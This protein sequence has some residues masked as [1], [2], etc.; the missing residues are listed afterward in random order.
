M[1]D[2]VQE[3]KKV[4]LRY[5]T[6]EDRDEFQELRIRSRR[7]HKKWEPS[8]PKG[9]DQYGS[10]AFT[11]YCMSAR[12]ERVHRLLVCRHEEGAIVG[13]VVLSEIVRGCFQSAYMGYWVGAP[14]VRRGYLSEGVSLALRHAFVALRLHRVE[15]NIQPDNKASIALAKR[16]GFRLEGFSERYLKIA[17]RW[18]DHERWAVLREEWKKGRR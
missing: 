3:G 11:R 15:A 18:R 8:P 17:G 5:P 12:S 4:L 16:C 7:F 14:F 6:R 13:S 9:I 10:A 2:I 1:G